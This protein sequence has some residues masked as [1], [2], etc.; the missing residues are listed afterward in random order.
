MAD[1]STREK[2]E[3]IQGLAKSLGWQLLREIMEAEIRAVERRF[4]SDRP[5]TESE[6][7]FRRGQ[8]NTAYAGLEVPGRIIS[9]LE[10]QLLIEQAAE[11]ASKKPAKAGKGE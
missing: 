2:L 10:S 5:M 11:V 1:R 9:Q 4:A 7:N 3:A 8:L 6:M